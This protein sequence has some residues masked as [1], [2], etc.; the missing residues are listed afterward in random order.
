[1]RRFFIFKDRTV[2]ASQHLDHRVLFFPSPVV[3]YIMAHM[4]HHVKSVTEYTQMRECG[5]IVK[6]LRSVVRYGIIIMSS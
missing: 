3:M 6:L 1:M 4:R 5:D 2:V